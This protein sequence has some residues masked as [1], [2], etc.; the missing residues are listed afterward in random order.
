MVITDPGGEPFG[1][2][3]PLGHATVRAVGVVSGRVVASSD[4]RSPGESEVREGRWTVELP[5]GEYRVHVDAEPASSDVRAS[6]LPRATYAPVEHAVAVELR[7]GEARTIDV[8]LGR[9]GHLDFE[10]L[11][12]LPRVTTARADSGSSQQVAG[13]PAFDDARQRS[14]YR[15]LEHARRRCA[16]AFVSLEQDTER[17][18]P[19]VFEDAGPF[20]RIGWTVPGCPARCLTPIPPGI[21]RL[22]VDNGEEVLFERD[23]EIHAGR[24]TVVRW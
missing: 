10:S 15:Q 6:E 23:V 4:S 13:E 7:R 14:W 8:Q 21:W 12:G 18:D 11:A 3:F 2:R 9:A 22:R 20:A 5:P 24:T 16:G 17:I 1:G 19:L